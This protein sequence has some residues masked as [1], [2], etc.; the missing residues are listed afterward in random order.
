VNVESVELSLCQAPLFLCKPL[1]RA[2]WLLNQP[3]D[4]FPFAAKGASTNTKG[5]PILTGLPFAL[6]LVGCVCIVRAQWLKSQSQR[7][8]QSAAVQEAVAIS[9]YT[10]ALKRP[11]LIAGDS[12]PGN[13]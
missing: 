3:R 12:V 4:S 9:F 7:K 2:I 10:S 11:D 6:S 8:L 5:S 13:P 1:K